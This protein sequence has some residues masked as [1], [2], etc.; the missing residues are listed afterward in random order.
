[1]GS[2]ALA[3]GGLR[4]PGR[5]ASKT[6]QRQETKR[7]SLPS[8]RY[9][10]GYMKGKPSMGTTGSRRSMNC[11]GIDSGQPAF[12]AVRQVMMRLEAKIS[13]LATNYYQSLGTRAPRSMARTTAG[14]LPRETSVMREMQGL[15][16][17]AAVAALIILSLW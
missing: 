14:P 15:F 16:A 2:T 6:S 3:L 13:R 9:R 11:E 7:T 10:Q 4:K 1:S 5:N 8:R 12:N 17:I